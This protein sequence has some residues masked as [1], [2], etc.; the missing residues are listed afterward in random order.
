MFIY[1]PPTVDSVEWNAEI[2][3]GV[4]SSISDYVE[5]EV[6]VSNRVEIS[7]EG[8]CHE[9]FDFSFFFFMKSDSP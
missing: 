9:I 7:L 3:R 2:L 4:N 5:K 6:P 1:C 8:Q